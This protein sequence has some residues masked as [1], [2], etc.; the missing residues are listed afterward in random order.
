MAKYKSIEE[1]RQKKKRKNFFKKFI[2]VLIIFS[3]LIVLLNVLEIFKGSPL[4]DI[5]KKETQ[6]NI[7]SFPVKIKNEQL[8]DLFSVG[9]NVGVL[10]KTNLIMV[11]ENGKTE[12]QVSHGYTNPVVKEGNKRFLT[13]DRGGKSFRV[14]TQKNKI[15]EKQ[16]DG[17]IILAQISDNGNVAVVTTHERYASV[18]TVYN[19]SLD[20]IYKYSAVER[21]SNVCFSPDNNHILASTITTIAGAFVTNLYELNLN[22]SGDIKTFTANG[23]VPL[24]ISYSDNNNITIISKNRIATI[25]IKTKHQKNYEYD[26]ALLHFNNSS[27]RETVIANENTLKNN[28]TIFVINSKGELVNTYNIDDEIIEIYS[29]GSRILVL[30]KENVYNFDMGLKLLNKIKITKSYQQIIYNGNHS[31][32]LSTDSLEKQRID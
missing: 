15:G 27:S 5:I 25:D 20:E 23:V 17:Q 4:N 6:S 1:Y 21:I 7:D 32:I 29:D 12:N 26:G 13:Y 31:Y 2:S 11:S 19:N 22:N 8:L 14:D 18:I 28:V 9:N 24:N 3:I 10:S 30:G 16:I